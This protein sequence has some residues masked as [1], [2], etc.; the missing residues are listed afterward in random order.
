MFTPR[1]IVRWLSTELQS[2][3]HT[4]HTPQG[5][6]QHCW[7][8]AG[9]S[10]RKRVDAAHHHKKRER[11]RGAREIKSE[12]EAERWVEWWKKSAGLYVSWSKHYWYCKD[13][14]KH[15]KRCLPLRLMYVFMQHVST[16]MSRVSWRYYWD[17]A[18]FFFF[19]RKIL[20][21]R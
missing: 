5:M 20:W 7:W 1:E 13:G 21:T 15:T 11:E 2:D 12:W 19:I 9:G 6:K 4:N 8:S 16:L 3:W 17:K 14:E 10:C 18:Y